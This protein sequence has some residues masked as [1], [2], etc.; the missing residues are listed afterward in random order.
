MTQITLFIKSLHLYPV[1]CS[2]YIDCPV[3]VALP[4]LFNAVILTSNITVQGFGESSCPP[5][6]IV[7]LASK[8][9][10][11]FPENL[12]WFKDGRRLGCSCD[13]RTCVSLCCASGSG[14]VDG[15]HCVD[16]NVAFGSL[17]T[18]ENLAYKYLHPIVDNP[19]SFSWMAP[20]V[21]NEFVILPNGFLQSS[22][23][24][25]G[26]VSDFEQYC[27]F[28]KPESRKFFAKVCRAWV[29]RDYW[30]VIALVVA[31]VVML[32]ILIG[33]TIIPELNNNL[34]GIIFRCYVAA[35]IGTYL[36]ALGAEFTTQKK[37]LPD[38]L[39]A[40]IGILHHIFVAFLEDSL[41]WS[42]SIHS[43]ETTTRY[44]GCCCI[45]WLNVMSFNIWRSFRWVKCLL[46][47]GDLISDTETGKLKCKNSVFAE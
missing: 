14:Q 43:P 38:L 29:R 47:G 45:F 23:Y 28:R 33:F 40:I 6:A 12:T 9:S 41:D 19:C 37:T 11:D 30:D 2:A 10:E 31:T 16:D 22:D 32:T 36:G 25:G 3:M 34:H 46:R 20:S 35:Y 44:C 24:A 13:I 18:V 26:S 4:S 42:C 17:P 7:D 21:L 15:W 5:N 8:P 1:G 39:Y 27:L